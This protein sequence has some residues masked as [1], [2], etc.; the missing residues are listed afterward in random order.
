MKYEV[1]NLF[2]HDFYYSIHD[3]NSSLS[4]KSLNSKQTIDN[5]DEL[6]EINDGKEVKR[7]TLSYQEEH[8]TW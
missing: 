5:V 3:K 1:H 4:M 8:T 2:H 7:L 6:F